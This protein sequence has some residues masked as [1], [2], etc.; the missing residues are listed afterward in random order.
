MGCADAVMGLKID[1]W[2][3]VV[4]GG[5]GIGVGCRTARGGGVRFWRWMG[6]GWNGSVL[7]MGGIKVG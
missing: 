6:S 2:N 5:A 7:W 3:W 4:E 1:A